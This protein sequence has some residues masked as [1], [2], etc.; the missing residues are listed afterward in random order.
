MLVRAIADGKSAV[1]SQ[2]EVMVDDEGLSNKA[3]LARRY[4]GLVEKASGMLCPT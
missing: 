3:A 2:E 4:L 1:G